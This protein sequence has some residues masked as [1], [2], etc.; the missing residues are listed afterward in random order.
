MRDRPLWSLSAGELATAYADG[1]S[2]VEVTVA[3]LARVREVN[4]DFERSYEGK[5]FFRQWPP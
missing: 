5:L 3:T 1:R 2:P 4:P